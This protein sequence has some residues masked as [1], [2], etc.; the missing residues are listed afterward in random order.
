MRKTIIIDGKEVEL[1]ASAAT[2]RRYKSWFNRDML[3]DFGKVY[4]VYK[5]AEALSDASGEIVKVEVSGEMLEIIQDMT[6]VMARQ[7][8][9]DVPK[10]VD[11][12]LDQFDRF[13]IDKIGQDVIMFWLSTV[14]SEVELKN[15]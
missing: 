10:N 11:D 5:E 2:L 13:E 15:V 8:N 14:Q 7:A 3:K 4:R 1:K 6:Y 12:W 9:R